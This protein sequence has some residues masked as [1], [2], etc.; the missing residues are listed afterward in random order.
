MYTSIKNLDIIVFDRNIE[1]HYVYIQDVINEFVS[2][3]EIND[4]KETYFE[5]ESIFD[6]T[7]GEV[8]DFIN[9]FKL[10]ILNENYKIENNDFK[11]KLFQTYQDYYRKLNA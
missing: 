9:E 5:V 7:L 8:V 2:K 1:M 3:L 4:A 6:T 10:N 11:Q